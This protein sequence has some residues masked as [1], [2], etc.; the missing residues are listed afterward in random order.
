MWP[1]H[2]FVFRFCT[3]DLYIMQCTLCQL[4]HWFI[5]LLIYWKNQI[6]WKKS[7][8]MWELIADNVPWVLWEMVDIFR[9]SDVS[10]NKPWVQCG[11]NFQVW[12]NY[13]CVICGSRK[14]NCYHC[15]AA[16]NHRTCP[17][18]APLSA[19]PEGQMAMQVIY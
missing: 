18:N 8:R 4:N 5:W 15:T 9:A 1:G 3:W 14:V 17:Q 7:Y 16:D 2:L 6:D 10:L 19:G 12:Q 13:W 11:I